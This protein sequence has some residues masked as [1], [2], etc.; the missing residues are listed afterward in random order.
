[1]INW[2]EPPVSEISDYIKK[3]PKLLIMTIASAFTRR[4]WYMLFMSCNA[5]AALAAERALSEIMSTYSNPTICSVCA[6]TS[7]IS[8]TLMTA[9]H[10]YLDATWTFTRRCFI[11][12]VS[13]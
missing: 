13:S 10:C 11:M 2:W 4:R 9:Y 5:V 3:K 6:F 1:M 12:V 7:T 8:M